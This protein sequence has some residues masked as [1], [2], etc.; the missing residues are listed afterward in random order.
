MRNLAGT[1]GEHV[2]E[3]E[4]FARVSAYYAKTFGSSM[5]LL[6]RSPGALECFAGPARCFANEF[7]KLAMPSDGFADSSGSDPAGF[8]KV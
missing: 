8:A 4:C 6:G 2:A 5:K 3:A 7:V 1:S